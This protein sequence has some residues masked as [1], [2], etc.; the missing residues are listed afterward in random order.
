VA[1]S[2]L[3][4]PAPDKKVCHQ[5]YARVRAFAEN[6]PIGGLHLSF[7][8]HI[9]GQSPE[10]ERTMTS[11]NAQILNTLFGM[12]DRAHEHM[13][14]RP[15][16]LTEEHTRMYVD[17]LSAAEMAEGNGYRYVVTKETR[18]HA[19]FRTQTALCKWLDERNL[20]LEEDAFSV[21]AGRSIRVLGAYQRTVH[22]SYDEFFSLPGTRI[23][24]LDNSEFTL[25]IL[26]QMGSTRSVHVLNCNLRHRPVFDFKESMDLMDTP[27]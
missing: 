20:H 13:L 2:R 6:L 18:V 4:N 10:Q 12:E 27:T 17:R 3:R 19:A 24:V 7:W 23:R 8:L 14:P 25:G 22:T 21:E 11:R 16:A 9:P 1:T 15:G 26:M 5:A